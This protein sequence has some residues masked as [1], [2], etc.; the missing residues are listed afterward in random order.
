MLRSTNAGVSWSTA[1]SAQN[2][3]QLEA[4]F[5]PVPAP[6]LMGFSSLSGLLVYSRRLRSR[7][8]G[9]IA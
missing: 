8:K 9:S 1:T 2:G 3:I 7:I 5:E 6:A 4:N